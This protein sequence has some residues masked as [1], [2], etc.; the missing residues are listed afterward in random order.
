MQELLQ[1]A[2]DAGAQHVKFVYDQRQHGTS[3][4]YSSGLE[5]FQGP[6]ILLWNDASFTAKDWA[7]IQQ[8]AQSLKA[9]TLTKTGRYGIG[10]NSVYHW[11]GQLC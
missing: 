4:T 1:N 6:A 7:N 5:S 3:S 8:P 10:F 9:D 11:T 2:D